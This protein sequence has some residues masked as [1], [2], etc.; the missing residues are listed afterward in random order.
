M[1]PTLDDGRGK[2]LEVNIFDYDG[3]LYGRALDIDILDRLRPEKAFPTL[4]ALKAQ[5][6][7]DRAAAGAWGE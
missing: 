2:T 6:A 3:D 4:A 7:R 1:R 5:L